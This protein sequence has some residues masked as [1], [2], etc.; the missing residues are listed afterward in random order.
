MNDPHLTADLI[1]E[2]I[3]TFRNSCSDASRLLREHAG[4]TPLDDNPDLDEAQERIMELEGSLEESNE[5]T[6]SVEEKLDQAK[7]YYEERLTRRYD[8]I[9]DLR[10]QI[11]KLEKEN[12]MLSEHV[13]E[14][15]E[16]IEKAG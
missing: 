15:L 2:M 3:R 11:T 14:L 4:V 6:T 9:R 10:L 8:E 16:Q 12:D 7:D 5:A 1:A 13:H